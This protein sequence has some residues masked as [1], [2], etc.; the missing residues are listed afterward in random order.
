MTPASKSETTPESTSKNYVLE[1]STKVE[2]AEQFTVDGDEFDLLGFKHLSALEEANVM[3]LLARYDNLSMQ[4]VT[5]ESDVEAVKIARRLR[6]KRISLL[7][8]LTTAP[9]E[10]VDSLPLE[11]QVQLVRQVQESAGLA[12]DAGSAEIA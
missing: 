1:L 8:K 2:P 3:A 6:D 4:L 12:N 5:T 7:T 11:A 9:S 10:I